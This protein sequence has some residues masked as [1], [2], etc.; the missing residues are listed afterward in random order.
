M[1]FSSVFEAD[2]SE[3]VAYLATEA[4]AEISEQWEEAVIRVTNLLQQHP[5]LGR[6]RADLHPEDIRTFGVKEFPNYLVFYRVDG[7]EIV[8]LRVRHGGMDLTLIFP[9]G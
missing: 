3:I 9:G 4:S 1:V 5:Q 2:F 8:F 6:I 7:D